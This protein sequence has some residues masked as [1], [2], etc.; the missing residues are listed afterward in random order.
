MDLIIG[1]AFAALAV[2]V[3]MRIFGKRRRALLLLAG[4]AVGVAFGAA[5]GIH[6]LRGT[7]IGDAIARL[8]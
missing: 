5:T 3:L 8:P 4:V 1:I 2:H 7:M 6:P